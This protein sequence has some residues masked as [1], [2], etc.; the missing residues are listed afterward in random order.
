MKKSLRFVILIL[1]AS[2]G[3]YAQVSH[4]TTAEEFFAEGVRLLHER[5]FEASL[6]AFE[7]SAALNSKQPATF[8]NIGSVSMTLRRYDKAETA[9]RKA[10]ELVPGEGRFRSELCASLS[11]QK[12]HIAAIEACEQGVR[13]TPDSDHTHT[14]R[15]NAYRAAGRNLQDVQ[16][17]VDVAAVQ[18]RDSET[19]MAM[20]DNFY[21]ANQDFARAAGLLETLVSM[22]SDKPQ[23][24]GMLAEA[25]LRLERE[26]ESLASA[27]TALR[28]D[29]QNPYGNYAMGL[30]FFELGQNEEAA[31]SF[32]KA[33]VADSGLKYARYYQAV[34]ETRRGQNRKAVDL[35]RALTEQYPD[36]V[37]FLV[38]HA[39]GLAGINLFN[40]SEIAYS[41][42]NLLK[43][44]DARILSGLGMSFMM[45][46]RH[47]EAIP[48]F[49]E[50][51][52]LRPEIEFYKMFV[53]V[54]RGRQAVIANIPSM[55]KDAD[56]TPR[57]I[58]KNHDVARALAFANRFDEAEV[59]INR[60]YALNPSDHLLYHSIGVTYS[61][62]GKDEKAR[63]AFLKAIE[64]G[65]YAGSYFAVAMMHKENGEFELASQAFS[66]GIELKPDTPNFMK[67]YGDLLMHHGKR[68]EALE[69][70]KR[71]LAQLPLNGAVLFDAGVL[72]AKLG[73]RTGA[74]GYLG[75]LRSVDRQ[76]ARKL[77]R[78]IAIWLPN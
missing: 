22:R 10:I 15:I 7:K 8:L 61:E 54:A 48:S 73:D 51:F 56:S 39:S 4:P 47:A 62:M 69:M 21:L 5:A 42:A 26:N 28:L 65:N 53:S 37:D 68:R 34:S 52:R 38:E 64:K 60:I 45:R 1:I 35:L 11:L 43:P 63:I 58:K 49:E 17:L 59:Y 19:V 67:S 55:M 31:D 33:S 18:F 27:R 30:I 44:K 9:F 12:K 29:P 13:L 70:Y 41:K 2:F 50:A 23:Y 16:R 78:C 40:E 66:K 74:V 57:D 20:A 75:T 72:S 3:L 32:N 77:E 71:S 6:L 24:H 14:A 36:N 46:G 25:Y 76:L